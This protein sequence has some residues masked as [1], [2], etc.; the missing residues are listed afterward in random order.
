[1]RVEVDGASDP[2]VA[3]PDLGD[4]ERHASRWLI[5]LVMVLMV[6]VGAALVVLSPES[7]EAADGTERLA[8]TA[9]VPDEPVVE[10][11]SVE[12]EPLGE[13]F[14]ETGDLLAS[15]DAPFG[16]D[17]VRTGDGFL[18]LTQIRD[19]DG[20]IYS[21]NNGVDWDPIDSRFQGLGSV[22]IGDLF[23]RRL[24][25]A[26]GGFVLT[27][28][29]QVFVSGDATTW[30]RL[31]LNDLRATNANP[32]LAFENTVIGAADGE[33]Q[34]IDEL[35]SEHSNIDIG[36]GRVCALLISPT[37]SPGL[38]VLLCDSAG[39]ARLGES[40]AV[41]PA[42]VGDVI[43]CALDLASSS[44][45]FPRSFNRGVSLWVVDADGNG[46]TRLGATDS[47][48]NLAS[49]VVPLSGRRVAFVDEGFRFNGSCEG[50]IDPPPDRPPA[51]IVIDLATGVEQ[52]ADLPEPFVGFGDAA[53]LGEV[54]T[55]T[56][57]H[58][59]VEVDQSL[60]TLNIDPVVWST[61]GPEPFRLS[62]PESNTGGSNA[63]SVTGQRAYRLNN[64]GLA[65]WRLASAGDRTFDQAQWLIEFS[66]DDQ[67]GEVD[68]P[69][70]DLND[71]EIVYADD[72]V[73]FFHG[74]NG[75]LWRINVDAE[76]G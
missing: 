68:L 27:S 11:R 32:F 65:V 9:T 36:D 33:V 10:S 50:L 70:G 41:G 72:S 71:A 60:A 58:L 49:E 46:P 24:R 38:E 2:T 55:A 75:R 66:E 39:R 40:T 74:I 1:M 73:V 51:V 17:V 64:D 76:V 52:R 21:S 45:G 14:D 28:T 19:G 57:P 48:W 23:W 37:A 3:V 61:L 31:G 59:L 67:V 20:P 15:T 54:G 69:L 22:D 42:P 16:L 43:S 30:T 26:Q 25:E 34:P 53:V 6:A 13:A 29:S 47:T 5:L 18:G 4:P 8:P 35:I 56:P 44:T 7:N 12:E 62:Q 63:V